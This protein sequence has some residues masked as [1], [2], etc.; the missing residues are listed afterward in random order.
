[1]PADTGWDR[2][3]LVLVA[4]RD[5][6]VPSWAE[7]AARAPGARE[8]DGAEARERCPAL[9]EVVR[10]LFHPH[11]ARVDGR[12][13]AAALLAGAR[14]HGVEVGPGAALGHVGAGPARV[15]E[16]RHRR[17]RVAARQVGEARELG[18]GDLAEVVDPFERGSARAAH[19]AGRERLDEHAHPDRLD[20]GRGGEPLVTQ[21][22][23]TEE[24]PDRRPG[25]VRGDHGVDHLGGELQP[26]D[27]GGDRAGRGALVPRHVG[28]EDERGHLARQRGDARVGGV[29]ADLG[30]ALRRAHPLRHV[31]GH[32]L[33]VGVERRVV[34]PVPDRVV[35]DDVHDRGAG[36][37]R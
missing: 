18:H 37:P 25:P 21:R 32:R 5:S 10:A 9:G 1:M 30:R 26:G 6:D 12:A 34:H 24:Q 4:T 22:G 11:A 8:I 36:P 31:A 35:A 14:A 20:A 28:R 33:D 19:D 7:I 15:G 23:A 3:G 27:A 29:A 13:L 17:V 16:E 2:C